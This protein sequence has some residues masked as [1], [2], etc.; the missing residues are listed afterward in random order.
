MVKRI[1]FPAANTEFQ[2]KHRGERFHLHFYRHWV[3]MVW[4][5]AKC[6]IKTAILVGVAVVTYQAVGAEDVISRR[7]L[8]EL[9]VLFFLLIQFELLIR[10]YRYFLRVTIITDRKVHRID[11]SLLIIDDHQSVDLWML[12]DLYRYQHSF[13]ENLLRY[14]TITLEAQE[15]ILNL[16]YVPSIAEIYE[17]IMHLREQAREHMTPYSATRHKKK[18]NV[19]PGR[20]RITE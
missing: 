7:V 3:C 5:F 19:P 13:I 6:F 16:H 10:I 11:K 8:L 2:G 20:V 4:P 1:I 17:Q 9:Y 18:M 15:T 14:G 12:Q